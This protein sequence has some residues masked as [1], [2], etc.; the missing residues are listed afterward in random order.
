[1]I[2]RIEQHYALLQEF[3]ASEKYGDDDIL[4][5]LKKPTTLTYLRFLRIFLNKTKR[6]IDLFQQDK[7]FLVKAQEYM[8]NLL[9]EFSA[10]VIKR[11]RMSA[12]ER[13]AIEYSAHDTKTF[14]TPDEIV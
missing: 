1:M 2:S 5:L 10:Y 4:A 3:F 8:S 13:F 14:Y 7:A 6:F 11:Q 9:P 12:E